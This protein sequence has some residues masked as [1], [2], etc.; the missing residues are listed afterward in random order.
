MRRCVGSWGSQG[1]DAASRPFKHYGA[2]HEP[3]VELVLLKRRPLLGRPSR[4][5]NFAPVQLRKDGF[6][7]CDAHQQRS[8]REVAVA[9]VSP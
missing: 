2:C 7:T 5:K 3:N 8:R 1:L 4:C 6:V 9:N